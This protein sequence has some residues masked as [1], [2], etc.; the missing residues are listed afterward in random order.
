MQFAV[1]PFPSEPIN[2]P[3]LYVS[4]AESIYIIPLYFAL[5]VIA[6]YVDNIS[7]RNC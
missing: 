1:A 2:L 5:F 7:A 4:V 6:M 3:I